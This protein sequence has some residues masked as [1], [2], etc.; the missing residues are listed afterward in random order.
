MTVLIGTW[1]FEGPFSKNYEI[2]DEP[3]IYAVLASEND[4]YE[5][6]ELNETDNVKQTFKTL[7][8]M[9]PEDRAL[10][11]AVYYC[12]DLTDNLREGLVDIILKEFEISNDFEY[13]AATPANLDKQSFLLAANQ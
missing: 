9:T 8:E 6:V 12:S 4:E 1:E 13:S 2:R 7:H 3:A 5:L 11:I 10:S